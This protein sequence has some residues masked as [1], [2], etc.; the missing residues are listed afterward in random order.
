MGQFTWPL[1]PANRKLKYDFNDLDGIIF[2]IKIKEEYK[3]KIMEIIGKKCKAKG[4]E[5]FKFY[6]AFYSKE[7]GCMDFAHLS[8]VK[9]SK[10]HEVD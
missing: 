4:R 9:Y 6:Q 2:G 3:L 8:L 1:T 5:D 7:K 10:N